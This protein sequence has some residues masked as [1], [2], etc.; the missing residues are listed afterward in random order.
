MII[1]QN[2]TNAAAH[3]LI[4]KESKRNSSNTSHSG[5]IS[6]VLISNNSANA[7]TVGVYLDD[8]SVQHYFCKN[9]VIPTG[10]SFILDNDLSFDRGKY[11]F[12]VI[13]AGT[14]PDITVIIK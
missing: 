9:V 11:S 1:Y 6:S 3:T 5:V 14:S 12:K 10:A 7:A 4:T 13:N 2:Y 8:D